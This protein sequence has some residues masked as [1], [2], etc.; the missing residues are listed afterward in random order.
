MSRIA[1]SQQLAE[2]ARQLAEQAREGGEVEDLTHALIRL[3]AR[4]LIQE[5][6]EAEITEL[7][8]RGRYARR[9]PG[10]EGARNGYKPRT[11]RCAEG[12][13]EINV[14]QVRG[15]EG[16]CQPALWKALK[17]R[18]EVLERLV[19]EM[20]ARGLSTRDIEDALAELT[21]SEA[22]LSRSTVSRITEVLHEEFEAFARRDLSDLDVVY[23]FA[24]AVYESLRRQAGCREGIL[25]TWA[26][27]SD[28]SKV[29]VHLSLGNRERYEDWLEHFRDLVRRG[30][31]APLTVTTDGAPG[32]I[33]AVEAIW[34]EAERIRCWVHKMRNV[35]DKVP[36]AVRP[37][38]KPYL[39]AIRDAPDI[40]RGR[41]LV[42]EVVE[43]FGREYPSAM[44]SLQEDLEASLAHLRL[45]AAHR[46]HIRTTNRVERSFEEE[47][48][49][50]KVLPRFRSERECLKLV[51]AVLWRASERWRRV[52]F[53]EHERKQLERYIEE[54]RRQR[55]Q[56]EAPAATVA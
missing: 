6:L 12:R 37:I 25:V 2:L 23:L 33:Q 26:I 35:L 30:L 42:A 8:G 39:E 19:V 24:D 5:L 36:E 31:K 41:R 22:L 53:S 34:P 20:Y 15:L 54:R 48:R 13:L 17:R 47:R 16:V 45:P 52:Q 7:L 43:R 1:P 56:K 21:G 14:P 46:K 4:K 28:G 50:A 9:E 10:Q 40:E 55:E 44:R 38:L 11:L 32:L 18:T 51:F 29:L 49:R 27:L 3:G